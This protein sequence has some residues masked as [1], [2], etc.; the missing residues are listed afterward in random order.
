M[1]VSEAI[2]HIEKNDFESIEGVC[3]YLDEN[4][5]DY[6]VREITHFD[7]EILI[8]DKGRYNGKVIIHFLDDD[9]SINDAND[10]CYSYGKDAYTWQIEKC[11]EHEFY[12]RTNSGKSILENGLTFF[13]KGGTIG[14]SHIHNV[15]FASIDEEGF[16]Q[17]GDNI[18]KINAHQLEKDG[19]PLKCAYEPDS[20]D[21]IASQ[22]LA[23][24]LGINLEID[25][26]YEDAWSHPSTRILFPNEK[27]PKD[28][29]GYYYIPPQYLSLER[30][31]YDTEENYED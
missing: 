12:H 13:S 2:S 30:E 4:N 24:E 19:F 16:R 1:T 14:N 31:E 28:N 26:N 5:I 10:F 25:Y 9:L 8:L 11:D 18:I 15:I 20:W 7:Q 22:F 21:A 17:Y 27:L 23:D 6:D 3:E 29:R